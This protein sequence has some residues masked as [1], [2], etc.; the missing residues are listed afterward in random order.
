MGKRLFR[1]LSPTETSPD[2]PKFPHIARRVRLPR[3]S[4]S[5]RRPPAHVHLGTHPLGSRSP[6]PSPASSA[7]IPPSRFESRGRT[8]PT[9]AL[10]TQ[11]GPSIHLSVGPA[12]SPPAVARGVRQTARRFTAVVLLGSAG[13]EAEELETGN[14]KQGVLEG[15]NQKSEAE[16]EQEESEEAVCGA[17]KRV[18]PGIVY[19]GHLPPRF[20]PLHVR[21]L[22]SAYGEVGRVFF[23]PE[24]KSAGPG[25]A[26][27]R[28]ALAGGWARPRGPE[29]LGWG[30]RDSRPAGK[31]GLGVGRSVSTEEST[32]HTPAFLNRFHRLVNAYTLNK[33]LSGF[34]TKLNPSPLSS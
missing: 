4:P 10:S 13:M 1:S 12:P 2:S 3:L 18:V 5:P 16:E 17:K 15:I 7:Y 33:N 30:V 31:P 28:V 34:S 26:G 14:E 27:R 9:S 22:L 8:A 29:A 19:L 20:R 32:P 6:A 23:Q 25:C 11:S 21:N 24:G